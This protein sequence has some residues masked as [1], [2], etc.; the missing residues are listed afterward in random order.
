MNLLEKATKEFDW[1]PDVQILVMAGYLQ[2]VLPIKDPDRFTDATA[3]YSLMTGLGPDYLVKMLAAM[4]D[5][6]QR[7]PGKVQTFDSYLKGI[8]AAYR[9]EMAPPPAVPT[10]PPSPTPVRQAEV[11]IVTTKKDWAAA[12]SL[13]NNKSRLA[14]KPLGHVLMR[15]CGHD[16]ADTTLSVCLDIIN[17][18]SRPTIEPY[19]M[20][21]TSFAVGAK[22]AFDLSQPF[23]FRY[24]DTEYKVTVKTPGAAAAAA[25]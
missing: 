4:A 8:M 17:A 7:I 21:G 25:K 15:F 14:D 20:N 18:E 9:T 22:P 1:A 5:D 16:P 13:L 19:L 6:A 24:R 12:T 2:Q 11:V 3:T 23:V 10:P